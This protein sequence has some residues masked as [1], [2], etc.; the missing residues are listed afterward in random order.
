M[1]EEICSLELYYLTL[2]LKQLEGARVDK[3]FQKDKSFLLVFHLRNEG[4]KLLKITFPS[5]IYLTE[6]KES[7][8]ESIPGF[9]K[10]LRKNLANTSVESIEQKGFERVL[11]VV[12]KGKEK[13]F[14]L[15]IELFGTGNIVLCDDSL[16]IIGTFE[17]HK[18]K[19]R[20]IRGG[21]TY[22]YPPTQINTL[23]ISEKEFFDIINNSDYDSVVKTVA[24]KLSLGGLYAEELCLI[25]KVDKN[26]KEL[27]KKELKALYEGLKALLSRKLTPIVVKDNILPFELELFKGEETQLFPSFSEAIDSFFSEKLLVEHKTE[28]KQVKNKALER[29]QVIIN[30]QKQTIEGMQVSL[31]ENQRK[32]EYIYEHYGEIKSI[33]EE[34][35]TIR[36]KFSWEEIK[37]RLKNHKVVKEINEKEGKITIDI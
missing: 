10:F 29:I 21:I 28:G 15:I 9:C 2:E 17:T 30:Q 25:A 19:D 6:Y 22:D 26:T 33:L 3:I 32:G 31:D 11:T 35:K 13:T 24:V 5:I 20:T 14:S 4:K 23:S 37:E 27:K 36:N 12:F 18:W 8:S 1:K 7:F 34:F 16:K